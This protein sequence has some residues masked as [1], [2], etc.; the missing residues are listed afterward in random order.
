MGTEGVEIQEIEDGPMAQPVDA[1]AKRTTDNKP[2]SPANPR[3]S[4]ATKPNHE[5]EGHAEGKEDEQ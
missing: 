5:D 4:R 3:S 1:V 2:D